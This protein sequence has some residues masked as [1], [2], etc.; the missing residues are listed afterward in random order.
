[1]SE[2]SL[3]KRLKIVLVRWDD[4]TVTT[5]SGTLTDTSKF[6]GLATTYEVG[7]LAEDTSESI[8]LVTGVAPEDDSVSTPI[9]IPKSIIKKITVIAY[10]KDLFHYPEPRT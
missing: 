3:W 4:A 7:F 9:T 8:K 2:S 1:L 5:D 10:A 6:G